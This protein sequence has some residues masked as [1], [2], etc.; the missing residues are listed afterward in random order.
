MPALPEAREIQ[1]ERPS[2]EVLR[3][4]EVLAKARHWFRRSWGAP[5]DSWL[6][7]R[8]ERGDRTGRVFTGDESARFL[9]RALYEAGYANQ[10]TSESSDDGLAYTDCYVTAVV[11]CAPPQNRP[12][13]KEFENCGVYLDSELRL[14]RNVRSVLALG[15]GAFG[16][17][18]G[19]VKKKGITTRGARFAHGSRYTFEG[20]PTLYA[21]YHPSP[22]N[23]Y[24]GRLTKEMLLS[25]LVKIRDDL[26]TRVSAR[27][28]VSSPANEKQ[29]EST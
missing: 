6:G 18:L 15:G 21:S 2:E 25:V 7:S 11:K 17:Y 8:C 5:H 23:T 13:A 10:P 29:S 1:R 9:V 26:K 27:T 22:Q 16:A 28:A 12:I 24:T 3:V 20:L 19:H 14:L 4:G